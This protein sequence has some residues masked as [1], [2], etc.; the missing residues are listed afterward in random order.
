[1]NEN[2]IK[3]PDY[4]EHYDVREPVE[5]WFNRRLREA[6]NTLLETREKFQHTLSKDDLIALDYDLVNY[7]TPENLKDSVQT[8]LQNE[9]ACLMIYHESKLILD[10]QKESNVT[11]AFKSPNLQKFINERIKNPDA[12]PK[13]YSYGLRLYNKYQIR[14]EE[15][16]VNWHRETR[17]LDT[18]FYDMYNK[19]SEAQYGSAEVKDPRVEK[20]KL[21]AQNDLSKETKVALTSVL[22]E[23]RKGPRNNTLRDEL[24]FF[25]KRVNLLESAGEK[26]G[27]EKTQ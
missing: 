10:A 15:S 19:P 3:I 23:L 18:L 24:E 16:M 6:V 1:L 20:L 2:D 22:D 25:F 8:D 7:F 11:K 5:A 27:Q 4:F 14:K 17:W 21:A 26:K 13:F 12:I 9:H